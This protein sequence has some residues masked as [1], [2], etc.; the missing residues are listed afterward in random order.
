MKLNS[1]TQCCVLPYACFH[2]D[3]DKFPDIPFAAF[4]H[5]RFLYTGLKLLRLVVFFLIHNRQVQSYNLF[6]MGEPRHME[7][8]SSAIYGRQ[9]L[10]S[11]WV[12]LEQDA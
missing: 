1:L 10:K 9:V 8:I 7:I 3:A 11:I 2:K 5:V 6:N 4:P 12:S